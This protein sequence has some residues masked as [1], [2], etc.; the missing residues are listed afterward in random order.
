MGLLGCWLRR[1][2][3]DAPSFGQAG[4]VRQLPY[5]VGCA[6]SRSAFLTMFDPDR[7]STG[8]QLAPEPA[9]RRRGT[10]GFAVPAHT[11]LLAR[12][13]GSGFMM[14]LLMIRDASR[15][16]SLFA[17]TADPAAIATAPRAP[18]TFAGRARTRAASSPLAP[19]DRPGPGA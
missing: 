16:M 19:G 1:E 5:R 2:R 11:I 8:W 10:R 15:V 3:R 7:S 6:A 13:P 18:K 17:T 9:P 14:G 4:G 12:A